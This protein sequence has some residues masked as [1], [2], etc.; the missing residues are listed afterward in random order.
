MLRAHGQIDEPPNVAADAEIRQDDPVAHSIAPFVAAPQHSICHVRG[1]RG[2]AAPAIIA[3]VSSRRRILVV[4]DDLRLGASLK[5][6]LSYEGHAVDVA[7]DG[8]AALDRARESRPDLVVL[9]VML[10]GVDGVEVCRRLRSASDVPILMLTAR[11]A[12]SDRVSGLDAGADDYLVKPFATEELLARVRALLRRT[13][14]ATPETL[15]CADLVMDVVAHEVRRADRAIDLTAL[16]FDVLE[17]FLRHQRQV[18]ARE[19]LLAAVWGADS[20]AISNVVDVTISG[21]RERIESNG[22][23][24]LLHTVR[25]VGYVLREP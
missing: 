17:H 9:D 18:L 10:P 3:A 13:G 8:N 22:A 4:D 7:T 23:P 21:L 2:R 16:Q 20:D 15:R 1:T 14:A 5:R 11:D 25:G 6:A 19:Q 12:V 24:R